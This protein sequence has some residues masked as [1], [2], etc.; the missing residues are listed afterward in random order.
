MA[1][2]S[3]PNKEAALALLSSLNADAL[4]SILESA[5]VIKTDVEL[6]SSMILTRAMD[7]SGIPSDVV[8][9]DLCLSDD[10]DLQRADTKPNSPVED[11][12]EKVRAVSSLLEPEVVITEEDY[13]IDALLKEDGDSDLGNKK[14]FSDTELKKKEQVAFDEVHRKYQEHDVL[15][16]RKT[17]L[18]DELPSKKITVK[19]PTAKL[20]EKKG[21]VASSKRPSEFDVDSTADT[22]PKKTFHEV[23]RASSSNNCQKKLIFGSGGND[24]KSDDLRRN[25][26]D[27][28]LIVDGAV[29]KNQV[30]LDENKQTGPP[31]NDAGGSVNVF[32]VSPNDKRPI[33]S[34]QK[35]PTVPVIMSIPMGVPHLEIKAEGLDLS[36]RYIPHLPVISTAN[37]LYQL[38]T[39]S[40][41]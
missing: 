11:A 13:D 29:V 27:V 30:V 36:R 37:P 17:I 16:K 22:S 18:L 23:A 28:D 12:Q 40:K 21:T 2:N 4:K 33:G 25:K 38:G 35:P 10:E 1:Q 19:E 5:G 20:S 7:E 31:G 15:E 8:Q 32:Q 9:S 24:N 41:P 39:N 6:D 14:D 34:E 3:P 26:G